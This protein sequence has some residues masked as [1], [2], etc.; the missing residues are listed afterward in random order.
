M[1]P[2]GAAAA[3]L[4]TAPS[5][6]SITHLSYSR[7][8]MKDADN[9][10]AP[11]LDVDGVVRETC[12][13][14]YPAS[15]C[16]VGSPGSEP[17]LIDIPGGQTLRVG[18]RCLPNAS[19]NCVGGGTM[20]AVAAV[21]YGA[22]VTLSDSSAPTLSKVTGPVFDPSYLTGTTD[23]TFDASDN[24]G[25]RSARLYVDGVAQPATTYS[26]DFTYTVPCS[27]RTAASLDLDTTQLTDGDHSIEVAASDP[28]SNEARST[29]RTVTVDNTAPDAPENL[30]GAGGSTHTA[31]D[32]SVTWTN[33]PGQVAPITAAHWQICDSQQLA[34]T[35]GTNE[36]LDPTELDG[37]T[38]PGP[39]TWQ[40]SVWLEDAA[41]HVAAANAATAALTY[42][43]LSAE[44]QPQPTT[45]AA[46]AENGS[47]EPSQT[48]NG[49]AEPFSGPTPTFR[50]DPGLR[51][52]SARYRHGRLILSGRTAATAAGPLT[53]RLRLATGKTLRIRRNLTGGRFRFVIRSRRRP[54]RI[55]LAYTGSLAFTPGSIA[56]RIR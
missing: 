39:G 46:A 44:P 33:P 30:A 2:A 27:N 49:S 38:V 14:D 47:A 37:L 32:F 15:S 12:S 48:E 35:S 4:F 54:R 9:N 7:W 40:L 22:T 43:V 19:S 45:A 50:R 28:A 36:S 16:A 24:V 26:C 41:G 34:C 11:T 8:L 31:N 20:H 3:W 52:R 42:A 10:W 55:S 1:P 5:G 21:L 51:L 56:A 53:I 18:V 13:I 23:A 17:T 25:I 6:T 29:A